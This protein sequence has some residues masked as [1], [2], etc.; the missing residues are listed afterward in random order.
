MVIFP[1]R[2][3][4]IYKICKLHRT[5]FSSFYN[6][7]QTNV[8]ILLIL[9]CSFQ[10]YGNGFHSSCLDQNFVYSW[11][12]PLYT[13]VQKK[14]DS[15]YMMQC[16]HVVLPDNSWKTGLWQ[17]KFFWKLYIGEKHTK[18]H[19]TNVFRKPRLT[20]KYLLFSLKDLYNKIIF[21]KN[22]RTFCYTVVVPSWLFQRY[23][24]EIFLKI[25]S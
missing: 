5:I 23:S 7:S 20:C 11:N 15:P 25:L 12:H 16:L 13:S 8:A 6:N 24:L 10:Q 4:N 18:T 22:I 1:A 14:K 9:R 17:N 3:A 19:N 2:N 21:P